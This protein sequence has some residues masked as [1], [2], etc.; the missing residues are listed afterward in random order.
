MKNHRYPVRC[1]VAVAVSLA[2]QGAHAADQENA[3]DSDN[4]SKVFTL[5]QITVTDHREDEKPLGTATV[6]QEQLQDFTK[7]GLAEA[8]NLIPGVAS[9]SGAGSRNEALIS[10]RGFDRW[11]VPLLMDGI[12]LYLPAD[13]RIDFDRFLTP[14]LSEIQVSKGYVSVLNGPDGMGGAINLVTRKPTKEFEG[15]IRDSMYLA[16]KGQY[17]GNST[18]VDVGGR[19]ETFYYQISA[20]QRDIDTWRLSDDYQPTAAE[21]GGKRDHVSKNDTRYNLKLGF[22]PNDTDEYSLNYV[23]QSG[24][25]HGIGSVTGT[26]TISTWDWPKWDTTSLYWL[27][28]TQ[29]N[30]KT[31]INTKAYRNT[32][33]NDLVAY[34]NVSLKTPNWISYYDD[35]ATGFSTEVGTDFFHQQTLKAALHYREDQHKEWQRTYASGFVEPKQTTKE[36]V[37][38]LALEDT[39]H[40]TPRFDLVGGISRDIRY[41]REAQEYASSTGL[42]NQPISDSY[43]TNYQGAAI[44]RYSDTGKTHL[45]VSE[46]TRFPTMFERFSSRFG[47]AISNPWLKPERARNTEIGV[48]DQIVQGVKGDAALFYNEVSDAIQSVNIVYSG[49]TY[50]QS[51]NVGDATYKGVELSLT[52]QLQSDLEVGGNYSYVDTHIHNP[53]DA[54][55]RLTT[56]PQNKA[57]VYARWTPRSDLT[58]IPYVEYASP[59]WS[60]KAT[61]STQYVRTG[62][63]TL[64]NFKVE[65][66]LRKNWDLSLTGRNLLDKNYELV[67]GYPQE[68][69]NFVVATRLQF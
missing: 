52:A 18:Y 41:S 3:A 11:Q 33:A 60:T 56:T 22:T 20:E 61:A 4:A 62:E 24:E 27:S 5:G 30:D 32:F 49:S 59:R 58:V 12:R 1:A 68:G 69:R 15:E 63:Y 48:A 34:T 50:S 53:N 28:H 9:T 36:D 7:E 67:D 16:G 51:Q 8:L 43:A 13:N 37:W 35:E 17:N 47:G 66:K 29:I 55:A 57:M 46:R 31:Y 64:M 10:V 23:Q 19:R 6:D 40:V 65:Y 42:F 45:S 26:S 21:N 44:Y 38:S 2:F 54:N 25:K 14:D 39:W